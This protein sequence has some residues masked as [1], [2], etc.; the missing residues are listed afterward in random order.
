MNEDN[1]VNGYYQSNI[2]TSRNEHSVYAMKYAS[3]QMVINKLQEENE[4][5]K[6][7]I[8]DLNIKIDI[9]NKE[10]S[11]ICNQV[12]NYRDKGK[13]KAKEITNLLAIYKKTKEENEK[14]KKILKNPNDLTGMFENCDELKG[15]IK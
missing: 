1:I 3:Q 12:V 4:D 8:A 14:L 10:K 7:I 9:R 6:A 2:K 15:D 13:R 5:L 11:I